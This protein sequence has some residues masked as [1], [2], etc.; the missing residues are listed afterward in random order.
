MRLWSL[1]PQYLDSVGLVALWREG[2]LARQ[3]LLGKTKGYRHHPQLVRFRQQLDPVAALDLYLSGV[4]EEA[5]KRG[6]AFKGDKI[7]KASVRPIMKVTRGQLLHEWAHLLSKL[8]KRDP[9]RFDRL[10]ALREPLS[11]PCFDIVEGER[12]SW[13]KVRW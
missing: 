2:L 8:E 10:V 12:E 5:F 7:H 11:H 6:Y 3:V 9:E 13:E 4:W 1:H